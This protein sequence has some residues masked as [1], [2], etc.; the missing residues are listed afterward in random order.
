MQKTLSLLFIFFFQLVFAQHLSNH[1][2]GQFTAKSSPSFYTSLY[3]DGKGKVKI[4]DYEE[5][6][7]FYEK[8]ILFL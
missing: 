7:I 6:F 5:E 8:M 1:L 3:F 4:N 2:K